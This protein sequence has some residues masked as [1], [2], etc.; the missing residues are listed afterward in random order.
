M[1]KLYIEDSY[2]FFDER[3]KIG[4]ENSLNYDFCDGC[5]VPPVGL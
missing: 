2:P 1:Y 5:D 3:T 4:D